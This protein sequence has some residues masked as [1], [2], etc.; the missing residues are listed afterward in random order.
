MPLLLRQV[1]TLVKKDL[2]VAA[3]RRPIS[4]TIR[5]LILPLAIILIVSYAQYFFNS[6][7]YFGVGNP[8]AVLG[9]SDAMARS[10]GARTNVAFVD[11]GFSDG[12]ISGVIEELAVPFR[13]AGRTIY[14][15]A[16]ESELLTRCPSS[17]KG[18]TSCFGAV[19]FHTSP[20]EPVGGGVWNY[21]IRSDTSLG[22]TFDVR[23]IHNDAQVS[24]PRRPFTLISLALRDAR[25]G[26][27]L[28]LDENMLTPTFARYT[29]CPYNAQSM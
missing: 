27:I 7:Q 4:T 1:W 9:L 26:S 20:S 8:T 15:M 23:S 3:V 14:R 25:H 19:V 2:L 10:S 11:N 5:A 21:T 18:T 24:G 17:Q 22:G 12:D 28:L 29:S 16:N 13:K 6:P